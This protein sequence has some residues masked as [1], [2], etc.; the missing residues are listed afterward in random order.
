MAK[1]YIPPKSRVGRL[2]TRADQL[3]RWSRAQA[4]TINPSQPS[5]KRRPPPRAE[6]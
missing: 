1:T 2:L 5:P 3:T 4:Y 6:R